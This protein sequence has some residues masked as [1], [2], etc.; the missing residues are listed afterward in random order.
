MTQIK[1]MNVSIQKDLH[2]EIKKYAVE[3]DTNVSKLIQNYFVQLLQKEQS[4]L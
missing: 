1:N 4:M 2:K 3:H